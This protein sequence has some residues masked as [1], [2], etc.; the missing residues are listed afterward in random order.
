MRTALLFR[1]AA[2]LVRDSR[3]FSGGVMSIGTRERT[4]RALAACG[5]A[6]TVMA[7]AGTDEKKTPESQAAQ[8]ATS[9]QA[10]RTD[11]AN[12]NTALDKTV[13]A[14]TDLTQ[15]PQSDLQPQFT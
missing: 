11:I 4:V 7:C 12:V 6:L 10:T 2:V 15:K 8:A 9:L 5:F 14:L 13:A 1:S 3:F